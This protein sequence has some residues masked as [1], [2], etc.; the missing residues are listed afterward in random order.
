M[1]LMQFCKMFV[2]SGLIGQVQTNQL[3][4]VLITEPDGTMYSA[5]APVG[6]K[7][8]EPFWF[9]QKITT[10]VIDSAGTTESRTACAVGLVAADDLT[11]LTYTQD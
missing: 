8:S 7:K 4:R 2:P 11:N 3:E 5:Y 6:T 9:A 10:V 1:T